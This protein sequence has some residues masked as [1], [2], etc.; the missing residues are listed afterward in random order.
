MFEA[1]SRK[2][3]VTRSGDKCHKCGGI[4]H[5]A[6]DCEKIN[7][8]FNDKFMDSSSSKNDNVN[9]TRNESENGDFMKSRFEADYED[10]G[11]LLQELEDLKYEYG[12]ILQKYEDLLL[13]KHACD[14]KVEEMEENSQ[15][16]QT[17]NNQL[18]AELVKLQKSRP[19]PMND[20]M[21]KKMIMEVHK[22]RQ[23]MTALEQTNEKLRNTVNEL[24][25]N[26]LKMK[27]QNQVHVQKQEHVQTQKEGI[28]VN[29]NGNANGNGK[30]RRK[31]KRRR[32]KGQIDDNHEQ[33]QNVHQNQD[34]HDNATKVRIVDLEKDNKAKD[35][36]VTEWKERCGLLVR[37]RND[38]NGQ[39][40]IL[41]DDY[42]ELEMKYNELE[43]KC[44]CNGGT[45]KNKDWK[46]WNAMDIVNWIINLDQDRYCKY[47]ERLVE[48]LM[49]EEIDGSCLKDMDKN[50][51]HRLGITAFKDKRDVFEELQVLT[52]RMMTND[53]LN[54]VY[55]EGKITPIV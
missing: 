40:N 24:Q 47:T 37:Q 9:G 3:L 49:R 11:P 2:N 32:S 45:K 16:L 21:K 46:Q 14:T 15:R 42:E 43:S 28:L 23:Q 52:E 54:N 53:G 17:E 20:E 26:N 51:L 31:R 48:S 5:W 4:G 25:V 12:I 39:L 50:D 35:I 13:R 10:K 1:G 8:Y 55:N 6:R 41:Q 38:L 34:H 18:K 33:T 44:I 19:N 27:Q 36:E 22:M 29:S 7:A 30:K